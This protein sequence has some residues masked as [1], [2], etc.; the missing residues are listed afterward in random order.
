MESF[1]HARIDIN[2]MNLMSL[3]RRSSVQHPPC[4]NDG[5][6]GGY[7]QHCYRIVVTSMFRRNSRVSKPNPC[8]VELRRK[9]TRVDGGHHRSWNRHA[10]DLGTVCRC[11]SHISKRY[12]KLRCD[13]RPHAY[14]V[15][16]CCAINLDEYHRLQCYRRTRWFRQWRRWRKCVRRRRRRR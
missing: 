9:C 15:H 8:H 5:R 7:A 16:C 12:V 13:R 4:N 3:A 14:C 10:Y 6:Y 1:M 2:Y 11:D